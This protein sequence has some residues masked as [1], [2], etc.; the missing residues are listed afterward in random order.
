MVLEKGRD[1]WWYGD[2]LSSVKNDYYMI[3]EF[4]DDITDETFE[5]CIHFEDASVKRSILC[6]SKR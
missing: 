2:K 5:I 4:K 3:I 6:F 1:I